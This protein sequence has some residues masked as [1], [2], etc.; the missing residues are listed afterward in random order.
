MQLPL[1]HS[2]NALLDYICTLL[3]IHQDREYMI[4]TASLNPNRLKNRRV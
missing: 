4:M 1:M 2:T 3:R